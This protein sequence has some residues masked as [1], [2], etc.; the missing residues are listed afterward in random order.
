MI[1]ADEY[2]ALDATAIATHVR[3]GELD[4]REVHGAACHAIG[5]VNPSLNAVLAWTPVESARAL[6][7]L[8]RDAPLAGVPFL[9][10]EIGMAMAGVPQRMGS[11]AIP[12]YLP[13]NDDALA[14]AFK[15]AGLVTLATT[16][17]PEFG[18]NLS[19]EP[20]RFGATRNPWNPAYSPAGSSGGAA[21]AVAAGMVPMAHA[22]DGGGS[23]RAPASAC[24]LVGLK[25]TRG[26]LPFG[27]AGEPMLFG[28]GSEFVVTRTVRDAALALA[29]TAGVDAG[30]RVI[31]PPVDDYVA[32][33]ARPPRHVRI[34]MTTATTAFPPTHPDCILAVEQAARLCESLGHTVEVVTPDLDV[35]EG[36]RLWMHFS[37]VFGACMV[38]MLERGLGITISDDKLERSV[39]GIIAMGRRMPLP[40]FVHGFERMNQ[41]TRALAALFTGVDVWLTPTLLQPPPRLGVLNADDGT[42]PF[43]EVVYRWGGWAGFLPLFNVAG[44]PGLNLPLHWNDAGLPVGVHLGAAHG[45]EALLLSLAAQLEQAQPWRQR[46]PAIHVTRPIQD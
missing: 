23:I 44:L 22:N 41:V 34:G 25:P 43:D 9:V 14:I 7:A 28:L 5:R 39:A 35:A 8:D 37:A 38:P 31:A 40:E 12:E 15:A 19:T 33:A 4:A 45:R 29:A 46:R 3:R 42:L 1:G 10:K 20:V 2:A 26:R 16:N 36:I 13:A 21:A 24:G 27:P 6:A 11:R 18:C 17:T 32:A 30:A